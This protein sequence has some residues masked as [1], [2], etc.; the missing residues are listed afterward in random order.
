MMNENNN[1]NNSIE[2]YNHINT[3]LLEIFKKKQEDIETKIIPNNHL[4]EWKKNIKNK[5]EYENNLKKTLSS[6]LL[7][8][9]SSVVGM[10]SLGITGM[11]VGNIVGNKITTNVATNQDLSETKNIANNLNNF[12][13]TNDH[14]T[15]SY[16]HNKSIMY[17]LEHPRNGG[18]L[19][20]IAHQYNLGVST[21]N[22]DHKQDFI[23]MA[24]HKL[25][26]N[27][28]ES[29]NINNFN[30]P[31]NTLANNTHMTHNTF[32]KNV[33]FHETLGI[34]GGLIGG[35]VIGAISG[36]IVGCGV[37]IGTN[38]FITNK[39]DEIYKI[40]N[41]YNDL[42]EYQKNLKLS[43]C[44]NI[45]NYEPKNINIDVIEFMLS[46]DESKRIFNYDDNLKCSIKGYFN[47]DL[48]L[49][50]NKNISFIIL[51]KDDRI[52]YSS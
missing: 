5:I 36:G 21:F 23:N 15:L 1:I 22:G 30:M 6:I 12:S 32:D 31:N 51:T 16:T 33:T 35:G 11:I 37:S 48:M 2:L 39:S 17:H 43:S 13:N 26:G 41:T 29:N 38:K 3:K 18:E 44:R 28:L 42:I 10:V 50:E 7:P 46:I 9:A 8:L 25:Y 20:H 19:N 24:H 14:H 45:N 52:L 47:N 27:V 34:Y 40:N 4:E 49:D